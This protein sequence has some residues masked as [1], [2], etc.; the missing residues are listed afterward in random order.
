[1]NDIKVRPVVPSTNLIDTKIMTVPCCMRMLT[2]LS[3]NRM[4]ERTMQSLGSTEV[5]WARYSVYL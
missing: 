5:F 1:M 4:V 3:A 2:V